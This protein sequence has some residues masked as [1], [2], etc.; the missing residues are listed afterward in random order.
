MELVERFNHQ[1]R[2]AYKVLLVDK[3]EL[4]K[5]PLIYHTRNIMQTSTGYGKNLKSE[6]LI[7][8]KERFYRVYYCNFSNSGTYY[9]KTKKGDIILDITF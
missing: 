3:S 8:Y 1:T 5:R 7:K 2:T 6:Y 9:I 4:I